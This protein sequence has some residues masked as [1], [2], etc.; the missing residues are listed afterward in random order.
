ML[1][2]LRDLS[3][4]SISLTHV[5]PCSLAPSLPH[6]TAHILGNAYGWYVGQHAH[7]AC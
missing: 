3:A 5:L 1:H 7:V 2:L 4:V 6:P